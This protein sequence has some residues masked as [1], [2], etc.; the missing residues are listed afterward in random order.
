MGPL[1]LYHTP[2]KTIFH[3]GKLCSI[4][5]VASQGEKLTSE[6]RSCLLDQQAKRKNSSCVT[7]TSWDTDAQSNSDLSLRNVDLN[8]QGRRKPFHRV[9]SLGHQETDSHI[10]P[11]GKSGPLIEEAWEHSSSQDLSSVLLGEEGLTSGFQISTRAGATP[12]HHRDGPRWCV[13]SKQAS[14]LGCW[15]KHG[16][17]TAPSGAP[18]DGCCHTDQR[19]PGKLNRR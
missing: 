9:Y 10:P 8:K 7:E 1:Q 4:A 19:L 11:P 13:V 14:S 16:G 3:Y 2:L 6:T 12:L 5:P 18:W 17:C 15:R